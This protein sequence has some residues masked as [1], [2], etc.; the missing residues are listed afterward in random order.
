MTQKKRQIN[1][2]ISICLYILWKWG[3]GKKKTASKPH[4][5]LQIQWIHL[6]LVTMQLNFIK[7]VSESERER[8]S[9]NGIDKVS[10]SRRRHL[11]F[12]GTFS[13][14]CHHHQHI[15]AIV[16]VNVTTSLAFQN[17]NNNKMQMMVVLNFTM[18]LWPHSVILFMHIVW[19]GFPWWSSRH[20]CQM[21]WCSCIQ[22]NWKKPS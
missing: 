5:N 17:N 10:S 7:W 6:R 13:C 12:N 14:D 20:F 1:E 8:K 9:M 19:N 16:S 4:N 15:G 18:S 2:I 3:G 22:M 11:Q 21:N